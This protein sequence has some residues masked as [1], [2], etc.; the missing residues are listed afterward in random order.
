MLSL[1]E[2][3]EL[4]EAKKPRGAEFENII[5]AAYNM[6]SLRQ[7]KD[8]AIKSA[9]THSGL[10]YLSAIIV[11]SEGPANISIPVSPETSFFAKATYSF[12]GPTI[13]STFLIVSVP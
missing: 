5:C 8:K 13:L 4:V 9:E 1:K 12:P 2:H 11:T 6:K 7:D 10:E 3:I